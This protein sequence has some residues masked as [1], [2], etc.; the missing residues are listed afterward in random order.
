MILAVFSAMLLQVGPVDAVPEYVLI[1]EQRIGSHD[2]PIALSYVG[3]ITASGSMIFVTQPAQGEVW[4]IT[5]ADQRV[6]L[7]GRKGGG[8]G[9]FRQPRSIGLNGDTLWIADNPA[10]RITLLTPSGELLHTIGLAQPAGIIGRSPDGGVIGTLGGPPDRPLPIVRFDASGTLVDTLAFLVSPRPAVFHL[11]SGAGGVHIFNPFSHTPLA[12][13]DNAAAG[14]VIVRMDG[15]PDREVTVTW[16]GGR[17][18][19]ASVGVNI[20]PIE[21]T[22]ADWNAMFRG[23]HP[24]F[25]TPDMIKGIPRPKDWVP[26]NRA[27]VAS[28]GDVWLGAAVEGRDTRWLIVNSRRGVIGQTSTPHRIVLHHIDGDDVWGVDLDEDD[29]PYVVRYRLTPD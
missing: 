11:T 9:E 29:V 7:L 2:G 28:N 6:N 19:E 10:R 16:L 22:N 21:I 27:V 5:A 13:A 26:V 18:A 17:R 3:G 23:V 14:L 12:V 4:A 1:P 15:P 25:R 8:P 20:T 24:Q